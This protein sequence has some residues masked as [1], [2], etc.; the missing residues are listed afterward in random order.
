MGRYRALS[1]LTALTLLTTLTGCSGSRQETQLVV[2]GTIISLQAE[3]LEQAQFDATVA[4]LN[5]R[6]R[7]MHTDWHAWQPG[8][9]ERINQALA[10]GHSHPVPHDLR[11]LL[12]RSQVLSKRSAGLFNP[13]AGNLFRAWGFHTSD[14]PV[15][16]PAPAQ[17][18]IDAW[19]KQGVSMDDLSFDTNRISSRNRSVRLDLGGVAKGAAVAAAVAALKRAGGRRALVDAGGDLAAY[20]EGKAWRIAVR[21]PLTPDQP[22]GIV[23]VRN[24]EAVFTSGNY[25]RYRA[26]NPRRGHVIDPRDGQPI[27]HTLSATVLASDPVLADAAATALLVAGPKQWRE[28]AVKMGV[29]SALIVT[30]HGCVELT[31]AMR[32]RITLAARAPCQRDRAVPA[33]HNLSN[34]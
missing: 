29:E 27:E 14:Y 34:D 11:Q 15:T 10:S 25:A 2:F 7:Q 21:D 4:D 13:A 19:L 18:V 26:D 17:E 9:L 31:T 20:S 16:A 30:E 28:V 5:Q 8:L 12:V 22:L 23:S 1:L 3:G 32:R 33:T 6:F 24:A